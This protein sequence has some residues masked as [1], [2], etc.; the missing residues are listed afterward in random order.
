[1][2]GKVIDLAGQRF[3]RW[4]LNRWLKTQGEQQ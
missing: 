1:M 4:N 2:M 3:G